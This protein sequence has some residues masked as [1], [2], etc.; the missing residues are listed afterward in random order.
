M[1]PAR[2]AAGVLGIAFLLSATHVQ[3]Y[4]RKTTCDPQVED[5]EVD[6]AGCAHAGVAVHWRRMP[7]AYRFDA[8]GSAKLERNDE[9]RKSVRAA[10]HRWSDVICASG[11]TSLR[12]EEQDDVRAQEDPQAFAIYFRDEGWSSVEGALALTTHAYSPRVGRVVSAFM[13]VNTSDNRFSNRD[14]TSRAGATTDADAGIDLE[15]VMTHEVGHYIGLA[16]SADPDSIMASS[17]C[18]SEDRC[19]AGAVEARRLAA[20]DE[21]AVCALFPPA[22]EHEIQEPAPSCAVSPGQRPLSAAVPAL[23]CLAAVLI[24]RRRSRS[25][26]KPLSDTVAL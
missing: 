2:Y 17:Y 5:C 1:S 13:E 15:A 21:E 6:E 10:F 24:A 16:H 11:R 12:F 23:L 26:S 8:V 22:D 19:S 7:I 18:E 9:T 25:E 3:A 14:D 4:C 20:D